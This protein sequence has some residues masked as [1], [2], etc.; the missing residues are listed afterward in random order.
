MMLEP[1]SEQWLAPFRSSPFS[2]RFELGGETFG[3]DAP[4]PRFMQAFGR[5]RQVAREVFEDSQRMF[6]I[7]AAFPNSANDIFAPARDGCAALAAAGFKCRPMHE[8]A[9]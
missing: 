6:G 9:S 8:T 2:L 7:V 4:V 1:F 3:N 5:A